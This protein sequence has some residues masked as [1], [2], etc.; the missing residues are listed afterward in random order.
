MVD[1]KHPRVYS[2]FQS[3]ITVQMAFMDL[4]THAVTAHPVIRQLS[5]PCGQRT[6]I[7]CYSYCRSSRVV[8]ISSHQSSHQFRKT[9]SAMTS[10][11]L[12]CQWLGRQALGTDQFGTN[13]H[14]RPPPIARPFSQ[15]RQPDPK[16][17]F[18]ATIA[19]QRGSHIHLGPVHRYKTWL[20]PRQPSSCPHLNSTTGADHIIHFNSALLASFR[21]QSN[22]T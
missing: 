20:A 3:N 14:D 22:T 10:N 16:L 9:G 12:M 17:R 11:I 6:E 13:L 15:R 4:N 5:P 21:R 7:W 18:A 2:V 8:L 19:Q 1:H